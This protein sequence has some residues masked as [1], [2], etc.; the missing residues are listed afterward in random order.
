[1]RT[2]SRVIQVAVSALLALP[3]VA[4]AHGNTAPGAAPVGTSPGGPQEYATDDESF[5]DA[6]NPLPAGAHGDLIRF[7]VRGG[8]RRQPSV[9]HHVPLRER[10]RRAGRGDRA[11]RGAVRAGAGR[12]V[13]PGP[14]R[15]RL[16]R[17]RRQVR[18]EPD[19]R[20]PAGAARPRRLRRRQLRL[21][22]DRVDRLR[23][24]GIAGW[25]SD[26]RR[27]QRRPQHARCRA[28]GTPDPRRLHRRLHRHR[29]VLRRRP[30]RV[31][32]RPARPG[33]DTE[34]THR[35]RGHR[36]AR[37]RGRTAGPRWRRFAP[38]SRR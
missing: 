13:R 24:P 8:P 31:V 38:S 22:G 11:R 29:R 21:V 17:A 5:F 25:P 12:R 7:Q 28:R 27:H 30:R 37:E 34:P 32:G 16:D 35:R 6:P 20:R 14:R 10:E 19:A 26:A 4:T 18:A 9:P 36:V 1:M 23:G 2:I 33:V 3:G 15:A